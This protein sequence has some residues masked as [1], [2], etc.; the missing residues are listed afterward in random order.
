M[1]E[2]EEIVAELSRLLTPSPLA[3]RHIVVTA[4]PTV[5]AVDPVRYISN[6]SSGKMG[7]ALAE[8]AAVRGARVTLISGPAGLPTPRGVTRLDVRTAVEM[9]AALKEVAGDDLS[10]ADALIMAAAV[11]DYR[12]AEPS[13]EKLKREGATL[14][15]ELVRNPDI[16]G[17]LG[18]ARRSRAPVLIGFALET[19]DGQEL[20]A[21][22]RRKLAKKK[23]DLMVANRAADALE[24]D[25]TR[26]LLVG[27][28]DCTDP[29]PMSKSALA[30]QILDWLGRRMQKLEWVEGTE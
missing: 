15:L 18:E 29:G 8:R 21:Q 23:V 26:A 14:T 10:G 22:A 19:A 24:G 30:D 3:L 20:I 13:Q 9:Q 7:F 17:E 2:P 16:L 28:Q 5:E 1:Q 12:V 6:R 27:V 4:G 11:A 25:D